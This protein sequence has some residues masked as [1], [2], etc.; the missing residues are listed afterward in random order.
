M[1]EQKPPVE[2][3]ED[4]NGARDVPATGTDNRR[5]AAEAGAGVG[6]GGA[7]APN[8]PRRRLR[9]L[10]LL[11]SLVLQLLIL[12]LLLLGFVLGTQTGLRVAIALAE[13]LAPD[14]VQ[15]GS[16]EG[17]IL[18]ELRLRGVKLDLPGLALGLGHLHLDWSPGSLFGGTLRIADLSASDIDIVVEPGPEKEPEPFELPQIELPIGI[19][20]ERGLVERLSF[21]QTGAAPGAAIR[22]ERAELSATALGDGVDLR[23]LDA[24][25]AQPEVTA[26]VKGNARLTGDYPIDLTLDWQFKQAPALALAGAGKITGD[27]AALHVT[28]RITGSAD[29]TLDADLR[30]VLNAPAWNGSIRVDEVR[31]PEIVA[32]AP[33]VNLKAELETDGN[34]DQARLT[35]SLSGDAPE[36]PDF[37]LLSADLYLGWSGKVLAIDAF[38]L[39]ETQSGAMLD[40]SGTLDLNGRQ[41]AFV[42]A[43]VWERLRWPLTGDAMAQSPQGTLKVDGDLD[44]FRYALSAQAFGQQIPETNLTLTGT[45]DSVGTKLEQLLLETLGGRVEGK[46]SAQW[47]P[48]LTWDLALNAADIDPGVQWAGLDGKIALKADSSGGL[49]DGFAYQAKLDAAL[50][51]YPAAVVN[52]TGTGTGESARID[53]LNIETLGGSVDGSGEVTWAPALTWELKLSGNDLDPGRQYAGL[54]G[55]V[56]LDLNSSGGLEQGFSYSVKGNANLAAYPPTVLDIA[57]TGDADGTKVETLALQLLGG[58]IDGSADVAWAPELSWNTAL[59]AQDLDPGNVLADWPGRIGG[60]IESSGRLTETGPDLSARIIDLGGDLRG[61]PVSLEA[62]AAVRGQEVE[63]RR[64]LANSGA[65][66]LSADGRLTDRLDFRFDFNSP[67][68]GSLLP[69]AQG[70]LSADGRVGGTLTAPSIALSLDGRDIEVSGQGIERIAG[71]ADV[72]LGEGGAFK[73][74]INGANLFAGGQRFETL[75]VQGNGSMAAHSLSVSVDGDSLS[76]ALSA[77]GDLADSGAYSGGLQ[78]LVLTTQEFGVWSLQRPARFSMDQGRITA[79]PLCIGNGNESGACAAFE[80]QQPG[81]FDVSL[82]A[83]RIGLEILDPML[84]E[85]T[86]MKG[87]VRAKAKFRGEGNVLTGGAQIQL[88]TGEIEIALPDTKDKLVFSGTGL[89]L[90]VTGAGL[91]A[92]LAVPVEGVG[93][94][95][96]KVSVP[97]FS[98]AGGGDPALRGGVEIRLTNLSRIS[99]LVP[100]LTD[101]TGAIDGDINLGGTLGKPAVSGA[102]ALRQVGLR[103][104]L[105]GLVISETNLSVESQGADSLTVDG[106]ALVGGGRLGVSGSAQILEQGLSAKVDITG[107]KLKVA[108]S[109]EY[110]ALVSTNLKAGVG[111]AGAAIQGE[112]VLPE[113]RIMPRTIPSGAVQPSPDVVMEEPA[114][115]K[116]PLPLHIDVLAK[117]GNN[118]RIDAFGLRGLLRGNLRITKVPNKGIVGDGQLEVFDGTYRVTIPGLGLVTSIGKP[119]TIKQGIVVFAKTPIDNPGLILN[120]VRDG[121]DVTAGV[122]VLGTIRNPKLAFF[123][124]SDPD[125][126]RDHHLSGHRRAAQ[127]RS[128]QGRAGGLGRHLRR[129]EAIR[130]VREQPRRAVRQGQDAL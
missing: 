3:P 116:E 53:A 57:G 30:D 55:R 105:L 23:R 63:L 91:N 101:V 46:G 58:R 78:S 26:D 83:E 2:T 65:T 70:S 28:H 54:D 73:I 52:L 119:L 37:G 104:P 123:S 11:I 1:S 95:D 18:G 75:G 39:N 49:D 112:I 108:D 35:G 109:K 41:P 59:I 44:A 118:V 94:V 77:D 8:R 42:L 40:L 120:A 128:Q 67:D 122:R 72:G 110:F 87:F 86:V 113:A 98:L 34:L 126:V 129:T 56:V 69:D 21:S 47:S 45:G 117:L 115:T 25:L 90:R 15:V 76:L 29:V 99:N 51:A 43:G 71:R 5:A 33:P 22:L 121:G 38:K 130:G 6:T 97:D 14:R 92:T 32:D 4:S 50:D 93:R 127:T 66:R 48:T 13:D 125:P 24:Q 17:R 16:V 103:V 106:G 20:I 84:P 107:D 31:L 88:P 102:L 19:D 85:M 7:A 124:E 36:L 100:D 60:R 82:D 27:L 89:D 62:D 12:I 80:Q 61:Y 64:L 9:P 79:G 74:D 68:L 10:R 81:R 111:P 114:A 96:G